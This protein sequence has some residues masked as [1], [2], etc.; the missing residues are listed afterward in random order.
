MI[1]AIEMSFG[2][3]HGDPAPDPS[4]A[5]RRNWPIDM[6]W[7]CQGPWF[8]CWVLWPRRQAAKATSRC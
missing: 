5:D 7:I 6:Y 4:R 1:R 2:L 3:E 8:Q